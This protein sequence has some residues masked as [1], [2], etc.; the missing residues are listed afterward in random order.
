MVVAVGQGEALINSQRTSLMV[1]GAKP[2]KIQSKKASDKRCI[3]LLNSYLKLITGIQASRFKLTLTNALLPLQVVSG[4]TRHIH[5]AI[6]KVRDA[7]NA[8][9]SAKADC[10]ILDLDFIAA[11]CYQTMQWVLMVAKAR[12]STTRSSP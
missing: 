9:S 8:T 12:A 10:A 5:Y 11:F 3:S 1:F 6:N 7:I 2:K 4:D